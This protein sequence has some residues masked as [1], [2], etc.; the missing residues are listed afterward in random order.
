MHIYNL[1]SGKSRHFWGVPELKP[2]WW[3]KDVPFENIYKKKLKKL[4]LQTILISYQASIRSDTQDEA[5]PMVETLEDDATYS[6]SF[7]D[8]EDCSP[9]QVPSSLQVPYPI[10]VPS[11]IQI[12]SSPQITPQFET[13]QLYGDT[14]VDTSSSDFFQM[15]FSR[16]PDAHTTYDISLPTESLAE[17]CGARPLQPIDIVPTI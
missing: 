14:D 6:L 10:Q 9:I 16:Q 7:D 8:I 17:L 11:P 12:P 1:F 5:T 13:P 3:L 15:N 4:D 2:S